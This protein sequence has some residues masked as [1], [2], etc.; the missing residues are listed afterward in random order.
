VYKSL[1][2]LVLYKYRCDIEMCRDIRYS[3]RRISAVPVQIIQ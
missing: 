1:V 3:T 2:V